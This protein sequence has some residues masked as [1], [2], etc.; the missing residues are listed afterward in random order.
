MRFVVDFGRSGTREICA[1]GFCHLLDI[2]KRR[3]E[4]LQEHKTE[5]TNQTYTKVGRR[6]GNPKTL[7]TVS[8][9]DLGLF[10]GSLLRCESNL[11]L[12]SSTRKLYRIFCEGRGWEIKRSKDGNT[13]AQ[14][15]SAKPKA[16]CALSTFGAFRKKNFPSVDCSVETTNESV[17]DVGPQPSEFFHS[18]VQHSPRGQVETPGA[19]EGGLCV[20]KLRPRGWSNGDI[21]GGNNGIWWP[22][23]RYESALDL[24][25]RVLIECNEEKETVHKLGNIVLKGTRHGNDVQMITFLRRPY[26]GYAKRNKLH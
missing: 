24:Y 1:F 19:V 16:I 2:G 13:K 5:N 4:T 8:Y 7:G 6:S 11:G 26:R 12:P 25:K 17:A 9:G 23:M 21:D 14:P 18:D 20:A 15:V 10:F 3:W 22:A